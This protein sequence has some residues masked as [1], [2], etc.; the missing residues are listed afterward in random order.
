VQNGTDTDYRDYIDAVKQSLRSTLDDYFSDMKWTGR[1][2]SKLDD[3]VESAFD[4][5]SDDIGDSYQGTGDC[6]RYEYEKDG[7]KL[8]VASDGDIF[9]IESPFVTYAQFCSPCAPGACY[10]ASPLESHVEGNQCYCLGPDWFD[11]DCPM[12]YEPTKL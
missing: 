9:V 5:I 3:A 12:P 7:Y 1:T 10:L 11:D 6:T 4:S 2:T 8:Q